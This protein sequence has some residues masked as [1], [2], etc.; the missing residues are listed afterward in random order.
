MLEIARKIKEAGGKLYLVGGAIRNKLLKIP[1]TDEDYCVTGLTCE[2]FQKLFPEAKIQ[3]KDFPVFILNQRE[4]ALARKERKIGT[5]HKEFEFIA[6]SDITIEEDL[7]RRDLT[8]NSIAQEVLTGKIIDPFHGKED[9]EKRILRKTTNAFVEDPLRV[10]RVARFVATLNTKLDITN[11]KQDSVQQNNGK[12]TILLMS[13]ETTKQNDMNFVVEP[14]TL[15]A[16][17]QLKQE[18]ASLSKERVFSEF[19]KALA[20]KKPSYFFETL[21]QAGV[22]D[23]HFKEIAQLIGQT[24]PIQYHPEGDSYA[25]TMIVVDNSTKLTD[26]LEIRFSCLVHDL[27]KGVTSKEMLP[28][29]YGHD[30]KGVQLVQNLASRIGVPNSWTKCGKT[31]CKWHMKA[32]IF[33]K[34]T[35]KKQIELIEAVEKSILGLEGLR[36]VVTC[37]KNRNKEELLD[38]FDNIKFSKLGKKCLSQINGITIQKKYPNL[39]G[40][41]LGEKLHEERINW[42]KSIDRR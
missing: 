40:K 9:I 21:K 27:G 11:A 17:N 14:E 13:N 8:I 5:G 6:N 15:K 26:S 25:H 10:Y 33:E 16:M 28:H 12:P 31:A 18:L 39:K 34:M 20:S 29:H 36:I 23:I 37:D 2:Q 19:R 32:G 22:L 7:S 1:V 30:E 42:I 41:E 4:I 38:N 24:Q 35:P 3:G